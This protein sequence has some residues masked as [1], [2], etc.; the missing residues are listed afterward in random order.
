MSS[1]RLVLSRVC[2][3]LLALGS[4]CDLGDKSIGNDTGADQGD[5]DDSGD[6]DG[7]A[8]DNGDGDG[9]GDPGGSCG[10][11]TLSII[12]DLD[13]ELPAFGA[14]VNDYLA[15]VEGT[16]LGDFSWLPNDGPLTVEHAGT[17]S[18]LTVT[19]TYEGGEIR[20]TEVELLGQSPGDPP[21]VCGNRLEIDVTLGFATEDGLFAE[22]FAVPLL[23]N[24]HSE[25]P[26]P[27]FYFSLDTE[28]LDGQLSL[29]DFEYQ[30]G[31]ITDLVL[32]GNFDGGLVQGDLFMEVSTMDWVGFGTV[33][34]FEAIRAP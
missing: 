9:D 28:A 34:S 25:E 14:T 20:L 15:L 1:H 3:A 31:E 17:T 2:L 6:G 24:S 21:E 5:P 7:D 19:V 29:D 22:S 32:M 23:I 26:Q 11:E 10:A 8:N 4:A 12:D 30:N 33:A 18:P 16:F 13:D 27:S